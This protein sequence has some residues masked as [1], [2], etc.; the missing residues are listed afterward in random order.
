MTFDAM[1]FRK[2]LGQ[3][4][5]GVTVVTTKN[6]GVPH[7]MTV[8]SFASVSLEPPLVLFCADKR[9]RT[10][11]AV[12]AA[13]IFAV[14]M[15]REEQRPV[16]DLFA[17]KGTDEERLK[18]LSEESAPTGSPIFPGSL[19]W[20]DCKVWAVHDAGDHVIYIGE[21]VAAKRGDMGAPL[22]Y[23]RGTY[24]GLGEAWRWADRYAAK[25][26]AKRFDEM[27]DFFDRMQTESPFAALLQRFAVFAAPQAGELCLDVGCG[28]GRLVRDLAAVAK[29]ATGVDESEPMIR[30]SRERAAELGASRASYQVGQ[31]E[32]LNF[33]DRWFD[34]VTAS[35]VIFLS[36]DP[37]IG[38][39]ELFRVTKRGG[40]IALLNPTTAM[41]RTAMAVHVAKQGYSGF[42][43]EALLGWAAAAE[44]NKPYDEARMQLELERAGFATERQQRELDGLALFTLAKRP[45]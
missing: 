26:Q 31:L 6:A 19:G 43:A 24:Q 44:A 4:A 13:G 23:Y 11:D 32:K 45:E 35:N 28:A 17:G 29:E 40:R 14:N 10:N 5:T 9:T 20:L 16:S 37:A 42:S 18:V 12:K 25:E 41:N 2:A 33:G 27:V 3:F 39:A 15:L 36:P 7:A 8:N 38:L 21:V 30:R 34:L 22:L 1:E